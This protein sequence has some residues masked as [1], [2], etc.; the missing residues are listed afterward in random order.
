MHFIF[1]SI[2]EGSRWLLTCFQLFHERTD[3]SILPIA[4]TVIGG[5]GSLVGPV[6]GAFILVPMSEALRGFGQLRVVLY[7]LLLIAFI[8]FKPQGLMNI[9]E[10]KYQQ[11]ELDVKV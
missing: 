10:R 9:L 2:Y 4:A 7:C 3:F 6:I 1:A 11:V 5:M 8:V